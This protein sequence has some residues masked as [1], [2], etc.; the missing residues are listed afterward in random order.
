MFWLTITV[1]Q[2]TIKYVLDLLRRKCM[3]NVLAIIGSNVRGGSI[4]RIASKVLEGASE[5]G[6]RSELVNL[7]DYKINHCL[8][9]W[10]CSETGNCV[11][12]DD[13]AEVIEK[14]K[15][16]DYIVLGSPVYLG[17]I[18]GIMKTF[19]DRHCGYSIIEPKNAASFK[20]LPP[21]EKKEK[22]NEILT[23]CYKPKEG[24]G[25]KKLILIV[26]ST[27]PAFIKELPDIEVTLSTL[28]VFAFKIGA[29]VVETIIN[30]DTLF[31]F[32]NKEP[33]LLDKAFLFGK[34]IKV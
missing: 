25:G 10:K 18:S 31:Q 24:F 6:S 13:C 12:D 14:F 3:A 17:S 30:D 33:D 29:E 21:D 32:E 11:Q 8:G 19:F 34:N 16:A 15:N 26:S 20:T 9:C 5:S 2:Y 28:K 22:F 7:Y 1:N 4:E 23:T 27:V